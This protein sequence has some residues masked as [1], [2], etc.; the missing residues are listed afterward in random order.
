MLWVVT[1]SLQSQPLSSH[2]LLL[3]CEDTCPGFRS[4]PVNPGWSHLEILNSFHIRSHSQ[5]QGLEL[6]PIFLGATI[7]STT[8]TNRILTSKTQDMCPN[9]W[10]QNYAA[11]RCKKRGNSQRRCS[12]VML[13]MISPVFFSSNLWHFTPDPE[14]FDLE[15]F[16][17]FELVRNVL[18]S[19]WLAAWLG[20]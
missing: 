17:W 13:Y 5:Y 3:S 15:V 19:C 12:P 2:G 1:S 11:Y 9:C 18:F 10:F 14:K 20:L 6:W 4:N 16:L 8:H 7:Q